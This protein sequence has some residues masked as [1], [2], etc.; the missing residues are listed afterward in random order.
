MSKEDKTPKLDPASLDAMG[1]LVD[2]VQQRDHKRSDQ[3]APER[4]DV[5]P[6]EKDPER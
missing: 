5:V 3:K 6:I 2:L 1:R 4:A